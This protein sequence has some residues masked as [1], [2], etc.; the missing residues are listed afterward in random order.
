MTQNKSICCEIIK[1]CPLSCKHCSTNATMGDFRQMSLDDYEKLLSNAVVSNIDTMF[2]SGGEP[3]LHKDII[4]FVKSTNECNIKPIIYTSGI[5]NGTD[6]IQP[7][8]KKTIDNLYQNGLKGL[9]LSIY[10]KERNHDYMTNKQGSFKILLESLDNLKDIN[11]SKEF[12]FLPLAYNFND[13][14]YVVSLAKKNDIKKINILK[15][16]HQGRAK[17]STLLGLSK[18]EEKQFF[19]KLRKYTD[20]ID[21]EVSKLY[22]CDH[23]EELL[24]SPYYAGINEEFITFDAQILPGRS[25]R[26][27]I[28]EK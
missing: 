21:I 15:L 18:D 8:S 14:D 9:S 27:L 1:T 13:I 4:E 22:D 23:Y 2:I 24:Y 25:Y 11:I 5:L 6:N 17:S 16:I 10:G 19:E 28:D 26:N 7:L 20:I 3:L 12:S